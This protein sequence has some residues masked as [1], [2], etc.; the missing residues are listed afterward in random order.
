[1][2]QKID[3]TK[4]VMTHLNVEITD[5]S[6]KNYTHI[7]W[8]NI[9]QKHVGGLRLTEQGFNSLVNA[10]IKAHRVAFQNPVE[11]SNQLIIWLDHFIDCPWYVTSE[12]IYVFNEKMAIQ[13]VL[14]SGDIA[15]FSAAKAK[16][17]KPGT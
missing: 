1:M 11:F 5:K 13:L 10:D 9:R 3:I 8:Q 2:N 16:I 6:F 15:R 7:L 4:Y 12:E 17:P 14:F